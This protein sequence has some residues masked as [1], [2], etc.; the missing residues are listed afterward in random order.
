MRPVIGIT[1]CL[2]EEMGRYFIGRDYVEGVEKAG[3]MP[4]VL[5]SI[6]KRS[7]ESLLDIL[8]GLLLS[9]GGDLDPLFF[10]EEPLPVTGEVDPQRDVFELELTRHALKRGLPILGICRGMQVLNVAAGGTISQDISLKF[11][12][13]YKHSQQAPRWY[14][15]HSIKLEKGTLA[16]QIIGEEKI[17]VNSFHHQCIGEVAPGFIVSARSNDGVEEIIEFEDWD[18]YIIGVQFH[19]ENM[20]RRNP[21]FLELFFALVRQSSSRIMRYNEE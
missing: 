18:K 1:C 5:P 12:S 15:T 6:N 4:I 10:G 14:P 19:P 8:D 2:N 7:I 21:V 17:R 20:W 13:F 3:G 16:A 11:D 9:G